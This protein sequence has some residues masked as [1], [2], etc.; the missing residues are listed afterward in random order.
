M[1]SSMQRAQ[2]VCFWVMMRGLRLICLQTKK[3]K[4]CRDMVFMEDGTSI[5]NTLKIHPNEKNE[6]PIA[7]IVDKP[8]RS[9]S[10]DDGEEREEQVRD[11]LIAN[12]EANEIPVEN[13]D[14]VER[15]GND[16]RYSKGERHPS[17]EW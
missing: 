6:G 15:F 14:R 10:C 4:K 17:K 9:S 2:T 11:H 16:G 1:V 5:R 3:I 12:E 13:D 7:V 8:S